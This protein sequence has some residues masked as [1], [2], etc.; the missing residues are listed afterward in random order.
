MQQISPTICIPLVVFQSIPAALIAVAFARNVLGSTIIH[1]CLFFVEELPPLVNRESSSSSSSSAMFAV[2]T[3]N[4]NEAP[5]R[6]NIF[7]ISEGVRE[8]TNCWFHFGFVDGLAAFCFH[9]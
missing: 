7:F 2:C 4:F 6:C 5:P 9:F 8:N 3:V 1:P